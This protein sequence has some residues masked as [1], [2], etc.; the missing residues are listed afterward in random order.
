MI[1]AWRSLEAHGFKIRTRAL[2]TTMFARLFLADLFI[3]GIGGGIYDELT[4]RIIERYYGFPARRISFS[5]QLCCCR[6]RAFL[7]RRTRCAIWNESGVISCTSRSDSWI[8]GPM[9]KH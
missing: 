9:P 7:M 6:C 5:R 1:D 8:R 2:T 4:D 3:H